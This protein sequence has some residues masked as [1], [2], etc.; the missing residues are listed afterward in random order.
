[1]GLVYSL[2]VNA[3]TRGVWGQ[4]PKMDTRKSARHYMQ[5]AALPFWHCGAPAPSLSLHGTE[6]LVRRPADPGSLGVGPDLWSCTRGNIQ[7]I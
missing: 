1:M 4:Y 2:W 5:I 3:L 7:E 6:C